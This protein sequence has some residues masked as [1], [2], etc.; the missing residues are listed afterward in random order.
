MKNLLSVLFLLITISIFA[1]TDTIDYIDI[2]PDYRPQELETFQK[3]RQPNGGF[4]SVNVNYGLIENENALYSGG[5][6]AYIMNRV[7]EVGLAG[8]G[9]YSEM[10][11]PIF[12]SERI[13]IFGGYGGL[14]M[15]PV[16]MPIKRIHFA[17]PILIGAGAVGYEEDFFNSPG[18]FSYEREWDEIFVAQVGANVVF[19]I[20]R[21]FQI[22]AGVQYLR[23]T[24]INIQELPDLDLNGFSGGFG[25]RFGW[26]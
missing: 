18:H 21:F 20:T 24:D 22:E 1:Q 19:N 13:D 25:L 12:N 9:F 4:I 5:K 16:I 6:I 17:F 11:H 3:V 8:Q 26:F 14:H 23:T 7:F 2:G 15:A 10:D